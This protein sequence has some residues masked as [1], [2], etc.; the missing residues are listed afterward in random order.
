MAEDIVSKYDRN[1][2][3]ETTLTEPDL[4]FYDVR[5]APFRLYGFYAPTEQTHFL[6][7]PEDIA[8]DFRSRYPSDYTTI[9][10]NVYRSVGSPSG[11]LGG[12]A[13]FIME[14]YA[15]PYI[16]TLVDGNFRAFITRSLR[17]YD[18]ERYPIGVVG[19]FGNALREVFE[20]VAQQEG[21]RI[22]RFISNPIEELI[23]YHT[24]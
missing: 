17:Q 1:M 10:A 5:K 15:N 9:I 14:H 7:L 23:K 22:E 13:P 21:L 2:L 18:V 4:C 3:V 16:Q 12:F 20:R 11:Y 24:I 6:R 19:G 8:A